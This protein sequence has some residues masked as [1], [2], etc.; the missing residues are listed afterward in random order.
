MNDSGGGISSQAVYQQ[1]ASAKFPS[2]VEGASME[3]VVPYGKIASRLVPFATNRGVPVRIVNE[4][5]E[6]EG[7]SGEPLEDLSPFTF[8]GL[9]NGKVRTDDKRSAC[10][11][12]AFE[13]LGITLPV[14]HDFQ[15]A[16]H[17]NPHHWRFADDV[18]GAID[19]EWACFQ[20][21][22]ELADAEEETDE[23]RQRLAEA[24]DEVEA[25]RGIGESNLPIALYWI[26]PNRFLAIDALMDAHLAS[27]YGIV[28]PK[29][30]DGA[31]YL[32]LV[33]EVAVRLAEGKGPAETFPD[34][35][36]IAWREHA[37]SVKRA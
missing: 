7:L 1:F 28:V 23:Q 2:H 36:V 22:L 35:C 20:A 3:W 29:T 19:K 14:P 16:P 9:F 37:E 26:R 30:L 6:R 13:R 11:K 33:D 32:D 8:F 15:G 17:L 31:A 5:V 4:F 12:L 10:V 27:A 34:L 25:L 18:P 21:A 24:F